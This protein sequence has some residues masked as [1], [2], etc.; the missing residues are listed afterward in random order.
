MTIKYPPSYLLPQPN[1]KDMK[2]KITDYIIQYE[3]KGFEQEEEYIAFFQ[4]LIDNGLAW[5][6][7]GHY[8]RTATKLVEAGLCTKKENK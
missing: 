3:T 2:S 7:Q 1:E 4:L 5:R 6:L 8:G